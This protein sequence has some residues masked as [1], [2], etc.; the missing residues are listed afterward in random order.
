MSIK[1]YKS[2]DKTFNNIKN[3]RTCNK[4]KIKNI[5]QKNMKKLKVKIKLVKFNIYKGVEI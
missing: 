4:L 5:G 3:N 2:K 1:K